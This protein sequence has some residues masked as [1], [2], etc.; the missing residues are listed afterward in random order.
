MDIPRGPRTFAAMLRFPRSLSLVS[1]LSI[2]LGVH[3]VG[4]GEDDAS[5]PRYDSGKSDETVVSMLDARQ[6]AELCESLDAYV[7][8]Y[9]SLDAVAYLA[10]LPLAIITTTTRE[11]CNAS[12]KDCMGL[13]PKPIEVSA[14]AKSDALCFD[15]LDQ[16]QATVAEL[17]GCINVNIDIALRIFEQWSCD[18]VNDQDVR[19]MASNMAPN[20]GLTRVCADID[21]A[22]NRFSTVVAPD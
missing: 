2:V 4:C 16:C 11:T 21:A 19:D 15:T 18:Q 1:S 13:F 10:C 17:E 20:G 6:Q 3:A 7:N 5:R 14:R 9:V 22:C 8:T 12:L